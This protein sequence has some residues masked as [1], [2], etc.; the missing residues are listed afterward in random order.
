MRYLYLE[1]T[2]KE[3]KQIRNALLCDSELQALYTELCEMKKDMDVVQL[4]PSSSTVLN[5]LSYS[6]SM[7]TQPK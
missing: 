7:A 3:T 2:E 1:T 4:Q 6:Q 5:I